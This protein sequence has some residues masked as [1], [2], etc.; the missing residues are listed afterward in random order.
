MNSK[1]ITNT[2]CVTDKKLNSR[3]YDRNFQRLREFPDSSFFIGISKD[4]KHEDYKEAEQF[5]RTK[6]CY[7][8]L[9]Q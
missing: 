7:S 3:R 1:Q 6:R 8:E 9:L 5:G 4:K 2:V